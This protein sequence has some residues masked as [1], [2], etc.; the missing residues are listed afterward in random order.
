MAS[1]TVFSATGG[2]EF[3]PSG[4]RSP[5]VVTS[6]LW[7]LIFLMPAAAFAAQ[8]VSQPLTGSDAIGILPISLG[9]PPGCEWASLL[10]LNSGSYPRTW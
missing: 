4:R 9:K 3:V 7:C 10:K 1:I 2:N 6:F 8:A 5:P